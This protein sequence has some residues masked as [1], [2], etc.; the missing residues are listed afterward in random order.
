MCNAFR[1][2]GNNVINKRL[3]GLRSSRCFG[4]D[5]IQVH[6]FEGISVYCLTPDVCCLIISMFTSPA[7]ISIPSMKQQVHWEDRQVSVACRRYGFDL[8]P[9]IKYCRTEFCCSCFDR[10]GSIHQ[11]SSSAY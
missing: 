3:T 7:K 8:Q 1:K 11:C 10:E 9:D 4:D 6:G 2:I 5:L